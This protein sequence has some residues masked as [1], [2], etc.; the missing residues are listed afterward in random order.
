MADHKFNIQLSSQ[1]GAVG[2]SSTL[3]S[4]LQQMAQDSGAIQPFF[5]GQL[6][7]LNQLYRTIAN[8]GES[9]WLD[10]QDGQTGLPL[11]VVVNGNSSLVVGSGFLPDGLNVIQNGTTSTTD[12]Q[13]FGFGY[14]N[15]VLNNQNSDVEVI[16]LS[17]SILQYA[18]GG[19]PT[20]DLQ[21]GLQDL[22]NNINDRVKDFLSLMID[23]AFGDE[24]TE[25]VAEAQ[26]TTEENVTDSAQ[27]ASAEEQMITPT[28]GEEVAADFGFGVAE[29]A[30]LALEIG[31]WVIELVFQIISKSITNYVRVY[32]AT[33]QEIEFSLCLMR[34][35]TAALAAPEL[36]NNP[37]YIPAMGT[38][39]WTPAAIIGDNP[40]FFVDF[41][42]VN[43]DSLSGVGYVLKAQPNGDFPGFNVLVNIPITGSNQLYLQ[44]QRDDDCADFWTQHHQG[45]DALTLQVTSGSY[46]LSIATNQSSGESDSPIDG[47]RGF[48]YQ[49]LILLTQTQ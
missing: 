17:T 16:Q 2:A 15:L 23:G 7:S 49:H 10:V 31:V 44:L 22:I 8:Q 11:K 30:N 24:E 29:A 14:V 13:D 26:Q 46:T 41:A 34:Q 1:I 39:A 21:T 35:N 36:P 38:P 5:A 37:V 32:N 3:L 4:N 6:S 25:S 19:L 28:E 27:Q 43:T 40:L 12:F 9:V 48:N 42:F 18:G 45:S 33:G 20:F 47:S